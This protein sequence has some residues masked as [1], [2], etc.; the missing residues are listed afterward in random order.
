MD[1]N[2][3]HFVIRFFCSHYVTFSKNLSCLYFNLSL[4]DHLC[5][6]LDKPKI[7]KT[8]ICSYQIDRY[9]SAKKP[10]LIHQS[11]VC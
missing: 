6:I 3:T 11:Y 8:F 9:G 5:K 10:K 4:I 1:Q 7:T 2:F